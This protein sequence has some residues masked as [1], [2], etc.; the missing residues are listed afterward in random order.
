[1]QI[2][3]SK[4]KYYERLAAKLNDPKTA[5]KTY[6]SNLKTFVH[7]SKIPLISLLPVYNKFV[8]DLLDKANLFNE[9]F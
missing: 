6:W 9:F 8:T 4:A 3:F 7:G 2:S 5:P 1:M